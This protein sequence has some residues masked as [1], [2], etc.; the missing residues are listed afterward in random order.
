MDMTLLLGRG[1]I[2]FDRYEIVHLLRSFSKVHRLFFTG[3]PAGFVYVPNN[4][5]ETL[6]LLY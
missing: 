1:D 2:F 4:Q 6:K 5:K 3:N